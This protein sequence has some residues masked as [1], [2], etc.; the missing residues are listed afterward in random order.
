MKV[1]KRPYVNLY[2]F[3]GMGLIISHPSGVIY[4]N[5]T[6]GYLC[7]HPELEGIFIPITDNFTHPQQPGLENYFFF[8]EKYGGHCY[9]GIDADDADYLDQVFD[10]LGLPNV[11]V[12]RE[13]LSNCMEAWIYI[14]FS[15]STEH[16][17]TALFSGFG[18]GWGVFTWENSD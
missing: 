12:D 10:Q 2:D 4:S 14:T 9:M 5:Q 13:R 11:R 15:E 8:E 6:G 3:T 7:S 16:W 1:I 17:S 18:S